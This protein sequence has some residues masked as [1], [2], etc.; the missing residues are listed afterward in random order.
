MSE[1][2]VTTF[3]IWALSITISAQSLSIWQLGYTAGFASYTIA[4]ILVG[5]AYVCLVCSLGELMSALPFAGGAYGLARCTLGFAAGFLVAVCEVIEYIVYSAT[6]MVSF[7]SILVFFE[8][9]VLAYEPLIWA[10][11]YAMFFTIYVHGGSWFWHANILTAVACLLV[12]VVWLLGSIQFLN[13]EATLTPSVLFVGGMPGFLKALPD[14]TGLFLGVEAVSTA[15]D[16]VEN[17]RGLIPTG[18]RWGIYTLFVTGLLSVVYCGG[19]PP[20]ILGIP[21]V[22]TTTDSGFMAMFGG[23]SE[24]S[25][26]LLAL[27]GA[28]STAFGFIFAYTKLLTALSKSRLLPPVVHRPFLRSRAPV[29]A[30]TMGA[31]AT[32]A[33]CLVVYYV[34]VVNDYVFDVC[35]LSAM[36]AYITQCYGYIYVKRHFPHLQRGYTSPFGVPG[37]VFSMSVWLLV[38]VSV[39]GFQDD[40]GVAVAG[41]LAIVVAGLGYYHAYG[42]RRQ[43]FSDEEKVLF[44]THVAKFN[45]AKK[46]KTTKIKVKSNPSTAQS[47]RT[48]VAA[49]TTDDTVHS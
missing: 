5:I 46:Y 26:V 38:I 34:P 36:T 11:L 21:N 43:S 15:A 1:Y 16:E 7:T 19:L 45:A 20:G 18:Q 22:W 40:D 29:V 25:V 13:Y 6:A 28:L 37:A 4:T 2:R 35:C 49:S 27:P 39:A 47:T 33:I 30:L 14:A 3:D 32:Y 41:Y 10:A 48:K 24:E 31:T 42:K 23:V 17:P 8:P 12:T 9:S 44:I